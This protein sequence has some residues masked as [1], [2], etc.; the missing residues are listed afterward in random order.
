MAALEAAQAEAAAQVAH[1]Q[2]AQA[3]AAAQAARYEAAQAEAA[4]R[5]VELEQLPEMRMV[6]PNAL[7]Y[8]LSCQE[9]GA[10]IA[11]SCAASRPA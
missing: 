11:R 2:A 5:I 3:E 6:S 7:P 10:V 4:A 8:R 9:E 1:L